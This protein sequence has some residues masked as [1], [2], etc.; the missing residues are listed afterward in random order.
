MMKN[1]WESPQVQGYGRLETRSMLLPHA[2]AN[3]ALQDIVLGPQRR[4]LETNTRYRSLD[5]QWHFSLFASPDA[6]MDSP[7]WMQAGFDDTLWDT[8][9]VPGTWSRQGYDKPHYTNVQMPFDS[10]PPHAPADNPTGVYRLR[11]SLDEDWTGSRIVMVI[12]SVESCYILYVNGQEVGGAKDTRLPSEYDISSHVHTGENTICLMAV[13]YSDASYVED[14]D[15]WWLGGILRSVY[16]YRT[17]QVYF[18]DIDARAQVLDVCDSPINEAPGRL[19]LTTTLG[20]SADPCKSDCYDI[21]WELHW[22]S[23]VIS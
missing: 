2:S 7:A 5:G 19:S 20:F 23:H 6:A 13:R 11:F 9:M 16:L 3:D 8:I 14:Q 17:G 21:T 1:F 22:S 18:Q 4:D 12:G 15:Q 10:L